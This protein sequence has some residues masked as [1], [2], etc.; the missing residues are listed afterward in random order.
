MAARGTQSKEV[1]TQKILDTFTNSFTYNGKEIRIPMEEN[2]ERIEIKV[3]LTCAKE[4]VGLEF[5]NNSTSSGAF[6][7][8]PTPTQSLK[9]PTPEEMNNVRKMMASLG[10]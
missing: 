9:E 6:E 2:G 3:T 8:S 1:I 10:L 7:P 4:N 5:N